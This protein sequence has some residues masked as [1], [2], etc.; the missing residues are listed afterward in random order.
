MKIPISC[1]SSDRYKYG[2]TRVGYIVG[3]RV[4]SVPEPSTALLAA[5]GLLGLLAVGWRRAA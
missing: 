4:A 2:A 1:H 3:F 5:L